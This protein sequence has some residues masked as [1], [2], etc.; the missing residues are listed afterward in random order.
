MNERARY[1]KLRKEIEHQNR[2]YYDQADPEIS[3][4]EYDRLYREFEDLEKKH[5]DWVT[6]DSP[7][8]V[9]GGSAVERFEK[10]THRLPMLSLEKAY[11]KE[12]ISAWIA[13]MERD[14]GRPVEWSFT[15]EPKID[16]DS[17]EL[18]YEKGKLALAATR[19]DGRVGENVTHT[20]KTIQTLPRTLAKAPDLVEIRGEAYL[21]LSDFR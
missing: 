13:S 6:P 2:L 11:S 14:L 3:D 21:N 1:D 5:P 8:Q 9:V 15:V 4:A 16:G 19:G 20:A 17:L 12:E 7:T 18:V 10:V